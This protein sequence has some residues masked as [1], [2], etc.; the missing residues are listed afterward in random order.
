M[1]ASVIMAVRNLD[2]A[3]DIAAEIRHFN[4]GADIQVGPRLDLTSP[5]SVEEFARKFKETGRPLHVLI[6]NAGANYTGE[7]W[8]TREGVGGQ[9]QVTTV[10][11]NY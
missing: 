1:G 2:A 9:C 11:W 7:P 6:N 10:S 8:F 4:P 5:D 3:E